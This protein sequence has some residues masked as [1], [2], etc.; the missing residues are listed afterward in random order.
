MKLADEVREFQTAV[1]AAIDH[2][3]QSLA[4]DIYALDTE[5]AVQSGIYFEAARLASRAVTFRER[6]KLKIKR[7]RAEM[8][9][10]VRENPAEYFG[11]D[12]KITEKAVA[13]AVDSSVV[14]IEFEDM[15]NEI[16]RTVLDAKELQ[17]AFDQ[18]RSMLNNEVELYV[19]GLRDAIEAGKR[20]DINQGLGKKENNVSSNISE[21]IP[22]TGRRRRKSGD[23]A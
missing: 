6:M 4:I 8:E 19:R 22:V 5:C 15:L 18:K 13:G 16:E 3:R 12:S 7:K 17:S 23:S 1:N 2:M 20:D 14:V 11:T 21:I 9:L 10:S